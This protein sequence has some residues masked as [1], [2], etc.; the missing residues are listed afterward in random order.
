MESSLYFTPFYLQDVEANVCPNGAVVRMRF[1]VGKHVEQ[2]DGPV[3]LQAAFL[4][5]DQQRAGA[6]DLEVV[7][8]QESN[9][10]AHQRSSHNV[11]LHVAQLQGSCTKLQ[12]DMGAFAAKLSSTKAGILKQK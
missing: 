6:A 1:L 3:R 4:A 7:R 2:A 9:R 10:L 5:E 11:S 12:A 8:Q